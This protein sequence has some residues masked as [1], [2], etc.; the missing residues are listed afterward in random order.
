MDKHAVSRFVDTNAPAVAEYG[1]E[2][3]E[4]KPGRT[5]HC[6]AALVR[7]KVVMFRITHEFY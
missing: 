4:R 5:T 6:V 3:G 1:M 2:I 7:M